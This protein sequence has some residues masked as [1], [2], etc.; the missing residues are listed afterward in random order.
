MKEKKGESLD[1]FME[2]PFDKEKDIIRGSVDS[3]RAVK[4]MKENSG[5]NNRFEAKEKYVGF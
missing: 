4:I 3:K 2:R 5:L 1:E